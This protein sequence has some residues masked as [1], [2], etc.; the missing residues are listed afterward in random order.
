VPRE[1]A[2]FIPEGNLRN[3]LVAMLAAFPQ[4]HSGLQEPHG[5]EK[6]VAIGM[7][8]DDPHDPARRAP[9]T[10]PPRRERGMCVVAVTVTSAD[11][12]PRAD[13]TGTARECTLRTDM[14]DLILELPETAAGLDSR[15]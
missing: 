5:G 13:I 10:D 6:C 2:S 15:S 3:G 1:K 11:G 4:W 9:T 14:H 7:W 12:T 8:R